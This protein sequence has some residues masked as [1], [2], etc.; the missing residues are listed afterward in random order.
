MNLSVWLNHFA[1]KTTSGKSIPIVGFSWGLIEGLFFFI[2]PD[3]YIL[4][5]TLFSGGKNGLKSWTY[6]IM[7]SIVSVII[8]AVV[9]IVYSPSFILNTLTQ[10]PGISHELNNQALMDIE[11]SGLPY[12]PFLVLSGIPLKVY[13][14][15][16]F[17]V[18]HSLFAVLVWTIFAQIV[19]IA[20]GYFI[21]LLLRKFA[22][23]S[24]DRNP[25][26][27]ITIYVVLW[28]I[29]YIFYFNKLGV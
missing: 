14:L 23:K 17:M 22:G 29:F 4:F 18:G 12:T 5:V 11:K 15:T 16:S 25:L 26:S 6:S 3:V 28:I 19:R 1:T 13:T 10:I 8:F 2:V 7:G 27:R 24:I 9:I 20:P 21:A